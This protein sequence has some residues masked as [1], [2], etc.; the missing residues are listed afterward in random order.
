MHC[1]FDLGKA[2]NVSSHSECTA[3]NEARS[4][5]TTWLKLDPLTT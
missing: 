1:T 3:R 2:E 4:S 5:C